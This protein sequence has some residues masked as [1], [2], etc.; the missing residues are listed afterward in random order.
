[1][2][3]PITVPLF[4]DIIVRHATVNKKHVIASVD[5]RGLMHV[6]YPQQLSK[7]S[8][9]QHVAGVM[10]KYSHHQL[11][12]H[13]VYPPDKSWNIA[14][15][16]FTKYAPAGHSGTMMTPPK[17]ESKTLATIAS[18][19][20]KF[21]LGE[22]SKEDVKYSLLTPRIHPLSNRKRKNIVYCDASKRSWGDYHVVTYA[23]AARDHQEVVFVDSGEHVCRIDEAEYAAVC[24][25]ASIAPRNSII[26]TDCR[27]IIDKW[28]MEY[29]EYY[30]G[31]DVRWV[32]GHST[33]LGNNAAHHL[34]YTF[35]GII[36]NSHHV[37]SDILAAYVVQKNKNINE[38]FE[39]GF[40]S[41]PNAKIAELSS[42]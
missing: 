18:V 40:F 1:M 25:A 29:G 19:L 35:G 28:R 9:S 22:A 6:T 30:P 2:T 17:L 7:Q 16:A 42:P 12:I 14:R 34:A 41:I 15:N 33:N 13:E 4:N 10:S 38:A 21:I 39:G 11:M 36:K 31:V 20:H 5:S 27:T 23:I 26:L 24:H 37:D 8:L 3:D 32:K